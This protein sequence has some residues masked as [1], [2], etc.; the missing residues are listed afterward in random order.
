MGVTL[1]NQRILT[2]SYQVFEY[3]VQLQAEII[4]HSKIFTTGIIKVTSP[5][6]APSIPCK[7]AWQGWVGWA[8]EGF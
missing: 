3:L 6:W 4:F 1:T 7:I 8:G 5:N 2:Q